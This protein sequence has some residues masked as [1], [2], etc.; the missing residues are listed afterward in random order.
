MKTKEKRR[1]LHH[2]HDCGDYMR[3]GQECLDCNRDHPKA[4]KPKITIVEMAHELSNNVYAAAAGLC[5]RAEFAG[6]MIGNGHHAAQKIAV[7]AK[8]EMLS[9]VMKTKVGYGRS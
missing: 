8:V 6:L 7:I 2:P 9:R 4:K 3:T 5:E 1:Q